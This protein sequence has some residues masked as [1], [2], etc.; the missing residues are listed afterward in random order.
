MITS[1][2]M[3]GSVAGPEPTSVKPTRILVVEDSQCFRQI[4]SLTINLTE[5]MEVCGEADGAA[6]AITMIPEIQPDLVIADLSMPGMDGKGLV[7]RIRSEWPSTRCVILSGHSDS[8]QIEDAFNHGADGYLIKGD[9]HEIING[10]N[11][12]IAGERYASP[13]VFYSVDRHFPESRT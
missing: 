8:K 11:K 13:L 2:D 10:L 7:R 1:S 5:G 4:L 9:I 3:D 6:Q 12:V